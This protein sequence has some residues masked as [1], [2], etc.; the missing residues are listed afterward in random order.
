[1]VEASTLVPKKLGPSSALRICSLSDPRLTERIRV[2]NEYCLP[3]KYSDK[4]YDTYVRGGLGSY[5][6][7]AFYHDILVGDM[8]CRLELT[9]TEN[10]YR[11]YI[12]TIA[13]LKPYRNMGIGSRLLEAVLDNARRETQ[14]RIVEVTLHMQVGS[15]A[16][17]FYEKFGFEVVKEVKDYYIDLDERDAL[18]MRLIVPQPHFEGKKIQKS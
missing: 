10:E 18:L 17:S 11:L 1:M 5:N 8:T 15:S 3:A 9:D 2:T 14:Y 16:R 4:F 12:M 13:V 7:V 6:Q